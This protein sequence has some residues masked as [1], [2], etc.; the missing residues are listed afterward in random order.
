MCVFVCV[1]VCVCV[2]VCVC[3]CACV[4]VCVCVCV[5]TYLYLSD[6]DDGFG[7]GLDVEGLPVPLGGEVGG[8]HGEEEEVR[9]LGVVV[10][11]VGA[12]GKAHTQQLLDLPGR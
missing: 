4:C 7:G 9:V 6:C 5:S 8:V 12:M 3:V 2:R 10:V 1:C 11:L